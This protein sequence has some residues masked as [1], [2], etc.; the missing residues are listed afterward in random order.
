MKH[1]KAL[2]VVLVI[3]LAVAGW[4]WWNSNDAGPAGGISVSGTVDAEQVRVSALANGRI[5]EANL[6]EG[7]RV[8]SGDVIYRLDDEALK[9]QVEQAKAGVRA[10]KA[11]YDQ[12]R[13]DDESDADIAAAKAQWEQAKASE[14]LA[15]IQLGYATVTSPATGTVTAVA[16]T[17]GELAAAGRTLATITKS[18]SLFVRCFV[19]EPS[20]GR[21]AIGDTARVDTDSGDSAEATVTFIASEAQFTPGGAQTQEQRA[22]LVYEVRVTPAGAALTGAPPAGLSPGM[23]VTVTFAQ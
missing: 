22:K 9:L 21:V 6:A 7:D 13:D 16:S 18:G 17:A 20:I 8:N 12:A 23:P 1:K 3:S 14:K 2:P 19:D 11:A 4:F 5:V 15:R 10:T